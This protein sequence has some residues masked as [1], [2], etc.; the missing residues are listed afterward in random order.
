MQARRWFLDFG[1]AC[2]R[3]RPGMT[4]GN[5]G[6]IVITGLVPVISL[7]RARPC[8]S[9]RDGRDKPGH[10]VEVNCHAR[11]YA[12][13]PRLWLGAMKDVDGGTSHDN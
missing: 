13:H 10:D 6:M 4:N 11:L 2:S 1:F 8:H 9:N 7:G 5:V 3:T 12:G